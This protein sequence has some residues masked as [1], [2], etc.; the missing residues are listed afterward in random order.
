M[1]YEAQRL[2]YCQSDVESLHCLPD[3]ALRPSMA[4]GS[5]SCVWQAERERARSATGLVGGNVSGLYGGEKKGGR[6]GPAF[7]AA[8][9]HPPAWFLTQASARAA[10][11]MHGVVGAAACVRAHLGDLDVNGVG[12]LEQLVVLE[13]GA[14]DGPAKGFPGPPQPTCAAEE[15]PLTVGLRH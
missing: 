11:T 7:P 1:L 3:V 6:A 12:V 13:G 2:L 5:F 4:T 10:G 8:Q 14:N 15:A 9:G